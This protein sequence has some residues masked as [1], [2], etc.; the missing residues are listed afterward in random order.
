M[1]LDKARELIEVQLG[2]GGDYNR[3]AIR[4]ILA[5]VQ[6]EHGQQAVDRLVGEMNL[7]QAFD[8]AK[9]ADFNRAGR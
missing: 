4:L 8:L 9:G 2:F 6:R 5:E 1:T 7:E 3:N